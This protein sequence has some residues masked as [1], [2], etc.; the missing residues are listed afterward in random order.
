MELT[1]PTILLVHGAF[2]HSS[3]Y[4]KVKQRLEAL[5]Y[6]VVAVDLRT[7]NGSSVSINYMDDVEEIHQVI[8]PLM[9]EG[10]EIVVVGHS[11][12]GIPSY[13]STEGESIAERAAGG[14]KGGVRSIVFLSAFAHPERGMHNS[15]VNTPA[16]ISWVGLNGVS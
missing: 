13:V 10:K 15:E 16:D 2:H 12:G 4:Y 1:K 5:S 8:L 9:D 14:K 3:C 6:P 7:T 11:Y